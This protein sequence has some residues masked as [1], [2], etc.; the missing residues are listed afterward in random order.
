[1]PPTTFI[2]EKPVKRDWTIIRALLLALEEANTPNAI[3]RAKDLKQFPEQEVAYT[4]RLLHEAGHIEAIYQE[5]RSGDGSINSAIARRLT[6]PGHELLDSIRSDK[7]WHKIQ[8][9]FKTSGL[10]MTFDLVIMVSK[11]I[12][13]SLLQ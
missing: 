12:M 11:K 7:V 2:L 5:S 3:V 1:M 10:E 13:E 8:E 4:I 6:N 9:K